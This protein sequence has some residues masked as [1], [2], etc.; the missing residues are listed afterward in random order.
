MK[1]RD[2]ATEKFERKI[3][4]I[5]VPQTLL[6]DG[7]GECIGQDFRRVCKKQKIRLKL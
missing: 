7:A 4:D 1:T 2:E 5:G 3:A 6:S